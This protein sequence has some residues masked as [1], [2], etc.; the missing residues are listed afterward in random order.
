MPYPAAQPQPHEFNGGAYHPDGQSAAPAVPSAVG[1]A[2]GAGP[3]AGGEDPS[4]VT[5]SI[6]TVPNDLVGRIIGKQGASIK[7]IQ[8]QSGAKLDIPQDIH[9]PTR[10]VTIRGTPSQIALCTTLIHQKMAARF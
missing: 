4:A 2:Q 9:A 10:D 5:V 7:E 3:K 1:G 8:E 6:L